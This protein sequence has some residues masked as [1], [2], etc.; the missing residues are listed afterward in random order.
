MGSNPSKRKDIFG[1]SPNNPSICNGPDCVNPPYD[2]TPTGPKPSPWPTT[3]KV[4]WQPSSDAGRYDI[5]DGSKLC[6]TCVRAAC[7][8]AGAYCCSVDQASCM[9]KTGGDGDKMHACVTQYQICIH[10]GGV[11]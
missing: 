6:K 11:Q 10:R 5:C 7:T 9:G 3:P 1:L 2:I 4:P 8:I